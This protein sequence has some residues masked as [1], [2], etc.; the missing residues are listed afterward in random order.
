M[1]LRGAKHILCFYKSGEQPC[2]CSPPAITL[3]DRNCC[4]ARA[5]AIS[6]EQALQ[7]NLH[8]WCQAYSCLSCAV[9]HGLGPGK[10]LAKENNWEDT[11]GGRFQ[12]ALN[13]PFIFVSKKISENH[14]SVETALRGSRPCSGVIDPS[15]VLVSLLELK[16]L[17]CCF[18]FRDFIWQRCSIVD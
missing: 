15:N 6:H 7:R 16:F 9:V 18:F 12:A 3:A 10:G 5:L 17:Q 1:K 4:V 8:T 13:G 11:V 2:H 14:S